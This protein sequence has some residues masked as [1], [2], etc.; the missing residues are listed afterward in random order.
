MAEGSAAIPGTAA[1]VRSFAQHAL[2]YLPPER[3]SAFDFLRAGGA[4]SCL[5]SRLDELP[6]DGGIDA[7]I[8]RLS[9]AGMRVAV[10]DI[11]APDVAL[12]PMRVV[13]AVAP[14]LHPIHCGFGMERL[15]NPRLRRFGLRNH[16]IHPFC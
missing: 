1:E 12:L 13:R 7:C 14:G 6:G 15:D 11:T 3:A 5:Y 8:G 2:Y 9:A 4:A 16:N 10:A